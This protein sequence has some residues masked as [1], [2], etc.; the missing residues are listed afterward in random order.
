MHFPNL[1]QTLGISLS[2]ALAIGGYK[3]DALV[4]ISLRFGNFL[5]PTV[6]LVSNV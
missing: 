3:I 4:S 5:K 6:G 2:G 1:V